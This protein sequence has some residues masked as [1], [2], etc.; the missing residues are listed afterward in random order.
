[1]SVLF[2]LAA[3]GMVPLLLGAACAPGDPGIPPLGLSR[4]GSQLVAWIPL[5]DGERPTDVYVY[6]TDPRAPNIADSVLWS[7]RFSAAATTMSQL[8]APENTAL[9]G[10][11]GSYDGT[12]RVMVEA[13]TSQRRGAESANVEDLRA[14][15]VQFDGRSMT[16]DAFQEQVAR[17][18]SERS[19]AP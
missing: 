16:I 15:R 8:L 19:A 11:D 10:I 4:S 9:V 17:A 3:L 7:A 14:D 13:V 12:T 18:C 6:S 2:R 1:V 5:C